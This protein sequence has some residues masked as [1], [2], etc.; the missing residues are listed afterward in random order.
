MDFYQN[1]FQEF[2]QYGRK[3]PFGT[4]SGP[5]NITDV[6]RLYGSIQVPGGTE[7]VILRR[8]TVSG[9]G[10]FMVGTIISADIDLTGQLQPAIPVHFAE[11]YVD[12]A[13]KARHD[14]RLKTV[15]TKT[16]G[17]LFSG[18]QL[19]SLIHP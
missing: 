11:V 5:S 14:G 9:D 16:L 10:Y 7:P 1:F 13:L 18:V 2:T 15:E 19:F 12:T 17:I 8:D 4:G 3:Q 6:C